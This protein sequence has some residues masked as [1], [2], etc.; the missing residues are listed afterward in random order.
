M[1]NYAIGDVQGCFLELK[2]LLDLIQFDASH[3]RLWFVGDLINRG[4]DSLRTIEFIYGIKDSCNIVLGNHDI[5]FLAIAEGIRKP[6]KED[7]LDELLNSKNLN[8]YTKWFKEQSL[9]YYE[10]IQCQKG[11]KTYLMSHAGIPPHW[12][13]QDALDANNEIRE[14]LNDEN[15]LRDYLANI[16]GNLPNKSCADLNRLERMRLNTNYLT[17][18]R[19]CRIDGELELETKGTPC[20]EPK[21]FKAWFKHP[22]RIERENLHLIFGHWAALDGKTDSKT[23]TGIDTG[24]VWGYKLTAYRLEDSKVFSY[25][26]IKK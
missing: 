12:S 8:L 21:G 15:L 7:T 22:L 2:G 11:S 19:F 26:R 16:Y 18:M 9:L 13:L 17:R 3:D 23:I 10:D 20:D 1:A 5:H 4:P 24:C 25:D 14:A 6:F